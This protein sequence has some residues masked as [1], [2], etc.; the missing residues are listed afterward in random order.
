MEENVSKSPPVSV[1]LVDDDSAFTVEMR[2][3]LA[4]CFNKTEGSYTLFECPDAETF[5]RNYDA[6]RPD[7]VFFD[8]QLPGENGIDMARKLYSRDKR[9]VIIF[10]TSNTDFAVQGYGVNALG[11][12]EKPPTD[13]PLLALLAAALERL[14]PPEA[15][16]LMVRSTG[17]I[18]PVRL[19]AVTHMES[20]N[21]RVIFH[22]GEEEEVVCVASLADFQPKLPLRF[23]QVHKSFLVNMDRVLILRTA[24]V[25]M[26]DGTAVSISK[27]F[28]KRTAEIFFDRLADET[29]ET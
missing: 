2:R 7:I 20:R 18:R 27:R 14:Y 8:I 17:G 24:E 21:R 23:L 28:R 19:A 5:W 16:T 26:D 9:P 15:A 4:C 3:T 12:I 10:I 29:R 13:K 6:M 11:F 22:C 25:I 1:V